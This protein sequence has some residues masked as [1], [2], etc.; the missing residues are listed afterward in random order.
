MIK[1]QKEKQKRFVMLS[2]FL[3]N[4]PHRPLSLEEIN[5]TAHEVFDVGENF[6]LTEDVINDLINQGIIDYSHHHECERVYWIHPDSVHRVQDIL[7]FFTPPAKTKAK[8]T[9][10]QTVDMEKLRLLSFFYRNR[11]KHFSA[12]G[13]QK[14]FTEHSHERIVELLHALSKAREINKIV[15]LSQFYRITLAGQ[16]KIRRIHELTK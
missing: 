5:K 14:Y 10:K 8:N 7:E 4:P 1:S 12:D 16:N 3:G 15:H 2:V 13:L 11:E 6:S 9:S